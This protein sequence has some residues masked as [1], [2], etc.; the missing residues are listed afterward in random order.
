MSIFQ[1][2]WLSNNN[3][4]DISPSSKEFSPMSHITLSCSIFLAFLNLEHFHISLYGI[5]NFKE[6]SLSTY[7]F[8]FIFNSSSFYIFGIFFHDYLVIMH[9]LLEYGTY[10]WN[11]NLE[12]HD[13]HLCHMEG[14]NFGYLIKVMPNFSIL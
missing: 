5:A 13:A 1:F 11:Q 12:A 9:F 8:S 2:Y 3:F 6:Y 7:F 4:Y 10:R 14:V